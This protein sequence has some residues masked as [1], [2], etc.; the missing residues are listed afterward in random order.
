MAMVVRTQDR[1]SHTGLW[2]GAV[3][4]VFLVG[5]VAAPGRSFGQAA[6]KKPKD[7]GPDPLVELQKVKAELE[8]RLGE[9]EAAALAREEALAKEHARAVEA[10]REETEQRLA[11]DR[12]QRQAESLRLQKALEE[13]A[14]REEAREQMAA[15]AVG[16]A[17]RGLSL[18]GYVQADY[19]MR[20]S[21]EDQLDAAGQ[22][23]NQDRFLIRRA[24]LGVLATGRFGEGRLELDGNTVRGTALRVFVA[25]ATLKLPGGSVDTP[26][27]VAAT[28]GMFRVPFG[29]E[30]A[31][32]DRLRLFMERSTAAR[33][34]FPGEADL[35]A[36]LVGGWHFLRYAL[37][38][39]NGQPLEGSS[40]PAL[41]P[42]GA[43]DVI[44]RA[45][46]EHA[47]GDLEVA[48][49]LS[50]L[51]GR[52]FHVGAT[53]TK[54]TVQWNDADENGSVGQG[55][56]V[57]SPGQAATPSASFS[58]LGLGA[59]LAVSVR[60]SG[61]VRTSLAAEVYLGNNLDRA[62]LPADPKGVAG[63]DFR[64]VGYYVAVVQELGRWR[65]G[66]RYDAYDPDQDANQ[67]A[68]G[69]PVPT[70]ASFST[71][72][73]VAGCTAA[74]GRVLI[75]YD[76]HRNHLGV[77]VDGMPANLADDAVVVRGEVGF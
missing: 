73:V 23:L 45:G 61:R 11:A 5:L 34:F 76:H 8:A 14:A 53:A 3:A 31:Q 68:K 7:P 38:L 71:L 60:W 57:G 69:S 49:G 19:Q 40:F 33:A 51:Y 41:D 54:P 43:K 4:G 36:R 46:V 16:A 12:M 58:R 26:P 20:Q 37:A 44:G 65:L 75:E 25:E 62:V 13:A 6:G 27:L 2:L 28:I 32:D 22:P 67:N 24:R 56:V 42:N 50:T 64:E 15:P 9:Q 17:G 66:V 74:W 18:Y 35:G 77:G 29:R 52:G 63:R 1:Q 70:D 10:L 72:A 39:Q 59:D 30:V 55:E 48:G 21:S 47:L